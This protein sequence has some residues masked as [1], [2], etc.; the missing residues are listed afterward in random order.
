MKYYR[1]T[2]IQYE[3]VLSNYNVNKTRLDIRP[4]DLGKQC[5]Y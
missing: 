3:S 4:N 5:C 1:R 2:A